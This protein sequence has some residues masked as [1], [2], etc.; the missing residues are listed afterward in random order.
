M[1]TI[2]SPATSRYITPN[3]FG[4]E[5]AE[6]AAGG[7]VPSTGSAVK[8]AWPNNGDTWAVIAVE[9]QA[10]GSP[11]ISTTSLISAAENQDYYDDLQASGGVAPYTW[12]I[13]SGSLPSW[14]HLNTS[15]GAITGVAPAT[16]GSTTFTVEVTD[17][18]SN[19]DTQSLTINVVPRDP[20]QQP[21]G[22]NSIWN[23]PI[24]SGATYVSVSLPSYPFSSSNFT[25]MPNIDDERIVLAPAAPTVTIAYSSAGWTGADRCGATGGST[26]GLPITVPV[27]ADYI[28]VSD[29]QNDS[30]AF[31]QADGR[32]IS[33]CQPLALC[34]AGGNGT[35]IVAFNDVD[36]YE[37]DGSSGSHGGSKLSA[38]GG[39]IRLG[40][41]RP[42]QTGMRHAIKI[43]VDDTVVFAPQTTQ[44]ACSRWPATVADA[45][46]VSVYGSANP[47]QYS[48]MKMG[49]LMAIPASVDLSTLGLTSEPGRQL[50][51]TL[52]NY[53]AY[54]VDSSGPGW[55]LCSE[56]GA[57]GSVRDQFLA[58][59]GM[60]LS[61]R[62]NSNTPWVVDVQ[63]CMLAMQLVDNNSPTSIGGGGIPLQPLAPAISPPGG[64]T[65]LT[66]DVITTASFGGRHGQFSHLTT[67]VTAHTAFTGTRSQFGHLTSAVTTHLTAAGTRTRFGNFTSSATAHLTTAGT[68]TRFGNFTSSATAHLTAAGVEVVHGVV[69]L[70]ATARAVFTGSRN[71][72]GNRPPMSLGGALAVYTVDGIDTVT[73][74][75]SG[76]ITQVSYG[77]TNTQVANNLAGTVAS[78][79]LL[80]GSISGAIVSG[81]LGMVNYGGSATGWTMQNINLNF[82][83]FND[84]TLTGTITNNGSALNLT[85]YTVNMYLKPTAGVVDTDGRVIKLSSGGGSPAITITSPTS[86]AISV[87]IANADLQDET[88]TFYR[89]DAVDASSHINTAMYGNI[90]YT[91]L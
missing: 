72:P 52:Q 89:I 7:T 55:E 71:A 63:T 33:Q 34:T 35:S 78:S 29:N 59:W 91:S 46:A 10:A 2:T 23:M 68:R 81:T 17:A 48:G 30:A 60:P 61:D 24:G 38:I 3:T 58:D 20:L 32:T 57:Q 64:S 15:T 16:S 54:I 11:V 45:G 69:T 75:V 25:P 9:V 74:T 84:I 39:S 65:G 62:V 5:N 12:S 8:I 56:G 44:A 88:H 79:N 22:V 47:T 42:G 66:S 19:T 40:E 85:G 43:V 73:A 31:L 87:F 28:A 4:T 6:F 76:T 51:W 49:A 77:G 86:G 41:L 67:A 14:A 13:S 53:G 80:G 70:A 83:E 27:P 1:G 50:A 90:T 18:V 36:L 26:G 21:F 37:A 82:A